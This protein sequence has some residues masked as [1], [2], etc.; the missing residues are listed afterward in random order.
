[1]T[2]KE[3]IPIGE[4]ILRSG[5]VEEYK[6]DAET[7]LGYV[8]GFSK[9][10]IFMNW[11]YRV[12]AEY[13]DRYF[14][15]ANMRAGGKPLQY[16]TG[17]QY[18]M[19]HLLEVNENVLIPRQDTERLVE[20]A[21]DTLANMTN[22]KN[23]LDLCTGSGAIAISLAFKFSGI[24]FMGADISG[25]ALEVARANATKNK[26]NGNTTFVKSDL[27]ADI[28]SGTFGKKFELIVSNPPYIRT[29]DLPLLQR[30]VQHEPKL[31]LDGGADGLDCYRR[32][33]K[34]CK[35]Y[36]KKGAVI[37]L[38]VGHD[39]AKAVCGILLKQGFSM[40]EIYRDYGGFDRVVKARFEVKVA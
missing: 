4:G 11:T 33:A 18:F 39:Q 15:L 3:L 21:L 20:V 14:D 37:L 26:V 29:D 17:R 27:F 9:Q 1:M 19:E 23:V 22:V 30:E 12:E 24:K 28:K 16:I 40:F 34:E 10:K 5:G 25:A 2:I 8:L 35:P 7:L 6:I 36:I 31:A 32:I 13:C 38:E